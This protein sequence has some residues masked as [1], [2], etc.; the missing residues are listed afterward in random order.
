MAGR[1]G[2]LGRCPFPRLSDTPYY[3]PPGVNR[4]NILGAGDLGAT[5]AR[6]LAEREL[7]R[8]I[9]LVDAD[10]GK[11]KGKALDIAQSG[12]VERFDVSVEGW[13]TPESA[14]AADCWVIADP[15]ELMGPGGDKRVVD[16]ARAMAEAAG[17][18]LLVV[19]SG[20]HGAALVE[21][22]TQRASSRE[23]VM[24]SA[25]LAFAA[26]FRRRLAGEL[27]LEPSVVHGTPIGLP[28]THAFV[29]Y[30]TAV[31]GGVPV[32]RLSAVAT[33][34]ALEALRSVVLG[35]VAL[36]HATVGVLA[37][38]S[39]T[40]PTILP[41]F[42]FLSGEYG[43]RGIALAVPAKLCSSRLDAVVEFTLEPVDRVTLDTAAERRR[44]GQG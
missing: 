19:A 39:S 11:A 30:G 12:P 8:H 42:A 13:E 6:R 20:Q 36:A 3:N 40:R 33:R 16:L 2:G 27:G 41:V 28:P 9:A 43:H 10:V 5:L 7:V 44:Q 14:P 34:R 38:L 23:R 24:G 31:A 25:P 37:A 32:E 17:R 29:P 18:G 4:V 15:P 1:A 21:A 35:P 22:A 26:A